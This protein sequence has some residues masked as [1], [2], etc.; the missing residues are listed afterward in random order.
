ME[1]TSVEFVISVIQYVDVDGNTY[2]YLGPADGKVYKALFKDNE[3]L[4][5]AK[6][7]DTVKGAELDGKLSVTG[8]LRTDSNGVV[9]EVFSTPEKSE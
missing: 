1:A 3:Q 4:L 2:V 6:A 8:I 7:G 9:T 5:F